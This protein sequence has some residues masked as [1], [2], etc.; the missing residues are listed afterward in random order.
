MQEREIQGNTNE[1]PTHFLWAGNFNRH[2]EAWD[3]PRN[4]HLFTGPNIAAADELIN[5]TTGYGLRMVLPPNIPTLQSFATKNWTRVDNVFASDTIAD[6][7]ITCNTVPESQP[8]KSDHL[9]I[10]TTIDITKTH[11][12]DT[13]QLN[14]RATDWPKFNQVLSEHLSHIAA[15]MAI[16][17]VDDFNTTLGNLNAVFAD[18]I[19]AVV[20]TSKPCPYSKRWW[21]KEL[22]TMRQQTRTLGRRAYCTKNK[23][24]PIHEAYRVLRNKYADAIQRTKKEHWEEWLESIDEDSVWMAH[25]FLSGPPSDGGRTRIPNLHKQANTDGHTIAIESNEGKGLLF[26]H[27]F[28]N[29]PA[30]D[31]SSIYDTTYPPTKFT[32]LPITDTQIFRAISRLHAYKAPG[33]D[34]IPNAVFTKCGNTLVPYLGHL[35]WATFALN[36][37]PQ[38]WMDSRTVILRK[39]GKPDYAAPGAYRPI[40]LIRTISKILS[41]C[42]A[43]E[44][45]QLSEQHH[46]LPANHFGCRAGRTTSDSLHYVTKTAKDA[47]HKGKV[48]S[49]LFL[50]IKGAFPSINLD[51]LIHDMRK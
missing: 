46:L 25:K 28:F 33:D 5:L 36:I 16:S 27:S 48:T 39:P 14:F 3:E 45:M 38:E 20:P 47:M 15:P 11:A 23:Q 2:H 50:D 30:S 42:V 21:I 31:H 29:A 40:A 4:H 17:T 49:A 1:L 10:I 18:T 43:D 6:H 19:A 37:Y 22:T 12:N 8:V 35:Y 26:F 9:P 51:R 34:N 7:I 41:S 24:D 44:L 32:F 13:P